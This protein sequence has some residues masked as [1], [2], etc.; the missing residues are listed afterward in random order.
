MKKQIDEIKK[1]NE[2]IQKR[3]TGTPAELAN[4]F[5]V[6]ER[7]VKG[8]IKHMRDLGCPIHYNVI[9]KSYEYTKQG[10]FKLGF[11]EDRSES[12]VNAVFKALRNENIIS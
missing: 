5:N 4:K 9:K 8:I 10:V 1:I 3:K 12:I 11:E 6:S 2:L 7:K